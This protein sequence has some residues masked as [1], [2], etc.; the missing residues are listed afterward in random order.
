MLLDWKI[1]LIFA[2]SL[3]FYYRLKTS[4]AQK[5][6]LAALNCI[7]YMAYIPR[8]GIILLAMLS[9]GAWVVAGTFSRRKNKKAL[10]IA[11]G[12][13]IL[14]LLIARLDSIGKLGVC[15]S[16]NGFL[17]NIIR[18]ISGSDSSE[19]L[20]VT[21]GISFYAMEI[22][23][24]LVDCYRGE[25]AGRLIDVFAYVGFFPT[26]TSGPIVKWH[27]ISDKVDDYHNFSLSN[28]SLGLQR[29]MLGVF[30]KKVIAD[31]LGVGVDAVYA[32]PSEYSGMSL[33]FASIGYSLQLL[34][35]FSGY[36]DMAIGIAIML[37]IHVPENFD[38]PY[39]ALDLSEFWK[40]WHI[41]LSSWLTEYIYF[42]LGGNRKGKIRTWLNT[43][44]TM[45]VSGL[46]HGLGLNYILWGFGHGVALNVQ[47]EL[48]GKL[49]IRRGS[50]KKSCVYRYMMQ[51]ISWFV[52]LC[53]V[54]VMWIP[55]RIKDPKLAWEVI[56]RIVT[57]APGITYVYTYTIVFTLLLALI[58]GNALIRKETGN[59]RKRHRLYVIFD[60]STLKGR[61]LFVMLIFL[62]IAF[63]Y[64]GNTAF[65]YARF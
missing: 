57:W 4:R 55:F 53:F 11:I 13:M 12:T 10:T 59:I 32:A 29:F 42:P 22:I 60:M 1:L 26:V 25:S 63:G 3:L 20:L 54:N 19:Q 48:R 33:L 23:S 6:Y 51:A 31:R 45:V 41:S 35:D 15:L 14:V 44:V 49:E 52:T 40:R 16:D 38:L 28:F 47:R 24:Y 64:F 8:G 36:S 58:L 34:A 56:F 17:A 9:F 30:E 37:G 2:I 7:I 46:W 18:T 50:K 62:I 39:L 65:I 5:V 43:I 21:T 27:E 61:Y